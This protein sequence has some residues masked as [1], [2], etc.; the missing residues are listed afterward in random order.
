MISFIKGL[1][2]TVNTS[3]IVIDCG[4]VGYEVSIGLN[5]LSKLPSI[6]SVIKIYTYMQMRDDTQW[7]YG[8]MSKEELSMFHMLISVSGIGPKGAVNMLGV[9]SAQE[10]MIAIMSGDIKAMSA[11]PGIGKKIAGRIILE[12][13]DKIKTE[14]ASSFDFETNETMHTSDDDSPKNEAIAALTALGYSRGEALKAI[15]SSYEDGMNTQ[16]IIKLALKSFS[17]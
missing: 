4:G 13:K 8:F 9:A 1:L 15:V 6:G 2:D 11:F 7:L 17:K 16:Q 14:S 5:T 3:S 12:L 10:I